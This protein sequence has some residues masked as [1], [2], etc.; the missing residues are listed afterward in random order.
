MFETDDILQRAELKKGAFSVPEGYFDSLEE[1]VMQRIGEKKPAGRRTPLPKWWISA[2]AA[3]AV[4]LLALS[5]RFYITPGTDATA[6]DDDSGYI[7]LMDVSSRTLAEYEQEGEPE[8]ISQDAIIEY[9][10]YNGIGSAYL[11]EQ[12][13]GAE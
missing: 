4:A 11:Y 5:I 8:D 2:A 9:L 13:A 6:Y 1:R 10:A 7:E 3:C 12:L